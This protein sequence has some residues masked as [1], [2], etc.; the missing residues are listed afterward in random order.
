M[1]LSS[2]ARYGL[3]AMCYMAQTAGDGVISLGAI[4]EGICAS[5]KYL[6][7]ILATLKKSELVVATRGANGG[8]SLSRAPQEISV[9]QILRSLEDGLKIIDCLSGECSNEC[10]SA[11]KCNCT[12]FDVWNKLYLAINSCLDN[13]SLASVVE[14]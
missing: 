6:E 3:K 12:T 10:G 13:M 2:R 8:Y 9:G 1:K 14:K 5:E 11:G 4:A 7:Q